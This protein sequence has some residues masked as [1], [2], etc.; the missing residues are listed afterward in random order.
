[1]H[2]DYIVFSEPAWGL[3][4]AASRYVYEQIAE[5]RDKGA[6]VILISS[7]LDEILSLAGRIIVFSRGT[8]AAELYPDQNTENPDSI[9]ET[10]GMYMTGLKHGA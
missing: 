8:V 10:I 4:I 2:R 3:D 5:L 6:A 7:N 1:Q 9:K